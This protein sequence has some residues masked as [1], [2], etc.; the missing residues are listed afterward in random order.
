MVKFSKKT[1]LDG[2]DFLSNIKLSNFLNNKEISKGKALTL[3][4]NE[5]NVVK[6]PVIIILE[7]FGPPLTNVSQEENYASEIN[8]LFFNE[9]T[10]QH[11][12]NKVR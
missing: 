4:N 6:N 12:V 1:L 8:L 7:A 3:V 10:H 2:R 9:I 5:L 11:H